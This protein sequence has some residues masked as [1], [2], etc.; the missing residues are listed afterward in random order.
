MGYAIYNVGD[1]FGGYGVPTI[2]EYP[3]CNKKIDRGIS[4]ACGG[5]PFSEK[6]CDRYFCEEHRHWVY[7][8][9]N[10]EKCQHEEDCDCEGVQLCER[11]R[12][13][14]EPFPYKPKTKEWIRH[15]LKDKSWEEWR[16]NNPEKV[17]EYKK[18]IKISKEV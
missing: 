13:G 12:D 15:V 11:C 16:Q 17:K 6:G 10:G 9:K 18:I 5:E 8:D 2:C 3:G 1:R 7:F 14:K 4:F